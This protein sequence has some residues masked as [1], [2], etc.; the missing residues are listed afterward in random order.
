[1]LENVD[2]FIAYKQISR[3]SIIFGNIW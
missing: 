1:V 3:G 2:L